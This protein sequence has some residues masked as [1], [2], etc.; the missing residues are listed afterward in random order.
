[1]DLQ[2]L[3]AEFDRIAQTSSEDGRAR[4]PFPGVEGLQVFL[5]GVLDENSIGVEEV[6][7]GYQAKG[8]SEDRSLIW[9][10]AESMVEFLVRDAT[11]VDDEIADAHAVE[12]ATLCLSLIH[13]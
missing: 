6:R 1:M 8:W 4:L 2:K 5:A 9:S 10:E 11:H 7:N 13:I 3:S 12:L